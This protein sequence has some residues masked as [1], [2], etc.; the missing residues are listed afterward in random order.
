MFLEE[1]LREI[2]A[3]REEYYNIF[4]KNTQCF[5]FYE[6]GTGNLRNL[7]NIPLPAAITVYPNSVPLSLQSTYV[8]SVVF[9]QQ[10]DATVTLCS[11]LGGE[12]KGSTLV[13]CRKEGSDKH[14]NE[15]NTL[16]QMEREGRG[17]KNSIH[18]RK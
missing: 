12:D 6:I 13:F 11:R 3:Y 4:I 5:P 18:N 2:F 1:N 8:F 14:Q 16:N 15:E 9:P 10:M 7:K 17:K